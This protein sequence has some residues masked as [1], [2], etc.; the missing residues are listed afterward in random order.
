MSESD[1]FGHQIF[2][3][4]NDWSRVWKARDISFMKNIIRREVSEHH[5]RRQLEF[6]MIEGLIINQVNEY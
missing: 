1:F 5:L 6:E 3:C 2:F 4:I